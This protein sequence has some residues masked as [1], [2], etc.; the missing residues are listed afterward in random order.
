MWAILT[1]LIEWLANFWFAKKPEPRVKD[2]P[3]SDAEEL[4]DFDR[5]P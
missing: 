1:P 5:L 4:S 3:L 2:A